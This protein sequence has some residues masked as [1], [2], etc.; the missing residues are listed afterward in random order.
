MHSPCYN[1]SDKKNYP[2]HNK[3]KYTHEII[4][5]FGRRSVIYRTSL[6]N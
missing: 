3:T 2:W 5:L 6:N 4:L 1:L